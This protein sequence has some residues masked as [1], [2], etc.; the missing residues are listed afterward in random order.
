M[1]RSTPNNVLISVIT[2]AYNSERFLAQCIESVLNQTH[3][4]VEHLV[5]DDGSTDR[6][7]DI[8]RSFPQVKYKFQ[9]NQGVASARN[10]GLEQVTGNFIAFLDADDLYRPKKLEK[11]LEAL[12]SDPSINCCFTYFSNFIE[13]GCI[14]DSELER[15]FLNREKINLSSMLVP[16]TFFEQVG[17]FN[18][19]YRTG[20]DF[21]WMTRAVELRAKIEVIPEDLLVRRIHGTNLSVLH[22]SDDKKLRLRIAHESLKRTRERKTTG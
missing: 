22:Q 18:T 6:T 7:E 21:E 16:T 8:A 15:Y 17:R 19:D 4:H 10:A 13:E 9:P 12:V 5:V 2:P 1:N 11:Q 14:L 20:S 3:K